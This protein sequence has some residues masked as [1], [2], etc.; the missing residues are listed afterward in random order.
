MAAPSPSIR[1]PAVAGTFYPGD[2]ATLERMV[3][4]QLDQAVRPAG[5]PKALI[6]PHAGYVYSG[7]VAATAYAALVGREPAVERVVLLGPSHRVYVRGLAAPSVDAF[8]TPLGEVP[9]DR[10]ALAAVLDLPQVQVLDDAHALEHSLEVHLPF[11]QLVL[12]RFALVPFSVGSASPEAVDEVLERLWGGP[13]T[14]VVVS[15]DLSHYLDYERARRMDTETTRA[16]ETLDEEG[17][18]EESACGRVPI[19]GL[20]RAARRHGLRCRTVDLRSSGDTAGPRDRVVGYGAYFF[21]EPGDSAAETT[22]DRGARVH[23]A[24]GSAPRLDAPAARADTAAGP[25]DAAAARGE[26]AL[27]VAA[28]RGEA[29]LEVAAARG[30]AA[31]GVARRAVERAACTGHP[32]LVDVATQPPALREEGAAFVTLRRAEALR[33][34]IGDLEA[35]RPLVVSVADSAFRAACRDPRFPPLREAELADLH[36]AVSI[37]TRPERLPVASEEELLALLE[38]GVDGL[39]LRDGERRATFLPAVW[40]ELPDPRAFLAQLRRKAGLAPDHWSPTT[41]A[42]RYRTET[43]A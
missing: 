12:G 1:P 11:L 3:R 40:E 18:H 32:L 15:S 4:S 7:P 30:E 38:P 37:L 16:I 41:L 9:V 6:V 24:G 25:A 8:A 21:L 14:L 33:G 13:E 28:A 27:E 23:V 20:L 17:L 43:F 22:A 31:L 5:R 42:W 2:A 26:A 34:C 39:I 36:V 10:E 29:A 19:R 35:F